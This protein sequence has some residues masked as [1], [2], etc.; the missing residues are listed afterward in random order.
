MN[1]GT[2]AKG[3]TLAADKSYDTKDFVKDC[4]NAG[5]TPHWE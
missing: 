2:K 4:R 3:T 1:G 5:I